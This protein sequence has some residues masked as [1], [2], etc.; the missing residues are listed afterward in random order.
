[1]KHLTRIT[2]PS[3]ANTLEKQDS[4]GYIF[5]QLWLTV[6]GTLLG[7]AFNS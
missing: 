6:M 1:M 2:A 4:F 7:K 3:T 5:L